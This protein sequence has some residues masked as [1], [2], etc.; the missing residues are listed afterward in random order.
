VR[1]NVLEGHA[2]RPLE[3]DSGSCRYIDCL[4]GEL[5]FDPREVARVLH[6][7]HLL[8]RVLVKLGIEFGGVVMVGPS[9]EKLS[10]QTGRNCS[11][12]ALTC[13][14]RSRLARLLA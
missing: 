8:L 13:R 11:Q 1:S 12:V 14:Y 5:H 7:F 6:L 10:C 3:G 9:I 4:F 2:V